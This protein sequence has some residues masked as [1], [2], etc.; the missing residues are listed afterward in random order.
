MAAASITSAATFALANTIVS[1]NTAASNPDVYGTITNDNG[2]NLLGTQVTASGTGDVFSDAPGLS[3]LGYYGGPT[4]TSAL[5]P[6]QP[7]HRRRR[8]RPR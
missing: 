3:P 8:C 4:E 2:H 1:G 7:G 6:R 5:L